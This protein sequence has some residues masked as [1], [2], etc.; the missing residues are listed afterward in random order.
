MEQIDKDGFD[1]ID[2]ELTEDEVNEIAK[3]ADYKDAQTEN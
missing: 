1:H 3:N 2:I